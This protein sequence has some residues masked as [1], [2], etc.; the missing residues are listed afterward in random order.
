MKKGIVFIVATCFGFAISAQAVF[1]QGIAQTKGSQEPIEFA[2]VVTLDSTGKT[3]QGVTTDE[4]GRFR[5]ETSSEAKEYEISFIGFKNF[6]AELPPPKDGIIDLGK[7]L[8]E[9]NSEMLDEVV[10]Q[11]ERSTTEFKLDKRVFNV[12][13]DLSSTGASALEVLNNVPSVNV[14]IEGQISLRGA[15]GVQILIDGKP[16][17]IA[18]EQGST[19]GTITADMIQR[20]E[21]ITNPSAKYE[22]EGT[23]G[24]INI[25]LKKEERKGLNGSL[26]LNTGI[27]DNHSVGLSINNRTEKFNLFSQLGVGFRELPTY[28]KNVNRDFINRTYTRTDGDE[29]R[30]EQFYNV[31]LGSDYYINKWNVITL[32]GRLMYEIEDQPSATNVIIRDSIANT[33]TEW[34]RTE[35]TSATNPKYR[36]ELNYKR[37]F[38]DDEDHQMVFSALGHYFSKD[39]S[40]DFTNVIL[41][42]ENPLT[43]QKTATD[44]K[45]EKYTFK[46]D[47]TKPVNSVWTIETGAQFE[48]NDVRN[49]YS[50]D[51]FLNGVWVNNAGFS[52]DFEYDQSVLAGYATTAYEQKAWGIKGGLRVEY[53]DLSTFLATTNQGNNQRFTNLFPS[54]HISYKINDKVSLQTGYSRR[55]YRPRLWDLNP[56]F[57][58]RN[59]YSVWTG[60]PL[61]TPEYTD[62]YEITSIY[63]LDKISWNA[64]VYYRYSTDKI[65]RFSTFNQG[66]NIFKPFNAGESRQKGVELNGKYQPSRKITINGDFN[67]NIFNRNGEFQDAAFDFTADQWSAKVTSKF[68]LPHEIDLEV[69]G[70]YLSREQTIQGVVSDN[71]FMNLGV[72][73]KFLKKRGIISLGVRDVFAS[74]IDIREAFETT[75]YTLRSRQR[76]R[77]ITLGISYG[78]GKGEAMEYSG[79]RRYR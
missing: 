18:S 51:D 32:S 65:E 58:V 4:T 35:E 44:F 9:Q 17:V 29:Y 78:F 53:T 20:V 60:N 7:V 22:A 63:I 5:F 70:R 71:I 64:G 62:S 3:L 73:K 40:S 59:N 39:Q 52:N 21:V 36:Y 61:L 48:S 15:T 26:S 76:G 77:F 47:Y 79:V 68:K 41:R 67:Y 30:N 43:N 69:T 6:R 2:T 1:V 57:N 34:D 8:L 37:D 12:G 42:G 38:P 19:L 74:R 75:F 14:N 33:V 46:L 66:I 24:I 45:E 50:V 27:P 13:Q 23:S 49:E 16:S 10:V 28:T 25:V 72:R 54:A 31:V 56:F 11:A 55:I